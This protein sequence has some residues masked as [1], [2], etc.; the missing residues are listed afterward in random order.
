MK[1]QIFSHRTSWELSLSIS[2]KM[3]E[4]WVPQGGVLVIYVDGREQWSQAM[5]KEAQ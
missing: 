1:Y 2:R 4:G 3:D 5:T